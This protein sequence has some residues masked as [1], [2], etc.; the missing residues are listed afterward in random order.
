MTRRASS[1]SVRAGEMTVEYGNVKALDA[2]AERLHLFETINE[3][4]PKRTGVVK[5]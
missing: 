1:R 4:A 5:S 3:I 2:L